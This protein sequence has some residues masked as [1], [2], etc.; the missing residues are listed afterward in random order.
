[1][2]PPPTCPQ[3]GA[4]TSSPSARLHP[5]LLGEPVPGPCITGRME[6]GLRGPG[7]GSAP[8]VLRQV[9]GAGA[10]LTP[11]GSQTAQGG[12][13]TLPDCVSRLGDITPRRPST[14]RPAPA[15]S[16]L[17]RV[18]LRLD[19]HRERQTAEQ[20]SL[21]GSRGPT[22]SGPLPARVALHTRPPVGA[23]AHLPDPMP[24]PSVP[25]RAQFVSGKDG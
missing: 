16:A 18:L 1:M 13:S 6:G 11:T 17:C 3:E 14:S 10:W 4:L 25:S 20:R 24:S 12:S 21:G 2:P 5:H 9:V 8:Q 19:L 23:S 22:L 15:W 7:R